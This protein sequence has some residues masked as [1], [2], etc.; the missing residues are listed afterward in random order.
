MLAGHFRFSGLDAIVLLLFYRLLWN[1]KAFTT[2]W[3]R[4]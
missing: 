3:S 1:T 2:A 4:R